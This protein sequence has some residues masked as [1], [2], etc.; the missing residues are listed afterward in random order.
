MTIF[1]CEQYDCVCGIFS[2]LEAALA[3]MDE[4]R[5]CKVVAYR[6]EGVEY[7]RTGLIVQYLKC[8]NCGK[9]WRSD[10]AP[11]LWWDNSPFCRFDCAK[12][13]QDFVSAGFVGIHGSTTQEVKQR[14]QDAI[15]KGEDPYKGCFSR[16][17]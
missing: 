16:G 9:R 7:K 15:A 11:V 13:T 8:E 10:T 2:T 12:E 4:C 17:I 1:L 5:D 3:H 14:V 6:E